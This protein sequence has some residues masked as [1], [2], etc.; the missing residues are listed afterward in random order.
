MVTAWPG[1]L[2]FHSGVISEGVGFSAAGVVSLLKSLVSCGG[3]QLPG[4]SAFSA[5]GICDQQIGCS[6]PTLR[7]NTSG[8]SPPT[9]RRLV[10][11][12]V[13]HFIKDLQLRPNR[14][15]SASGVRPPACWCAARGSL[16]CE[17]PLQIHDSGYCVFCIVSAI[18]E[19]ASVSLIVFAFLMCLMLLIIILYS[20]WFDMFL[21][22]LMLLMRSMFLM[23]QP[24]PS[25]SYGS[26]VA[27]ENFVSYVSIYVSCFLCR[28]VAFDL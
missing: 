20:W 19:N 7:A 27:C 15:I 12:W 18:N 2:L 6:L 23:G 26:Y 13:T 21:I 1:L 11:E 25:M 16:R 24:H 9:E 14:H 22:L 10:Y 5:A 3:G 4:W 8:L 17:I 28:V